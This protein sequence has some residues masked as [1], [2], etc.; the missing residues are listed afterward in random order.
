MIVVMMTKEKYFESEKL[1]SA[2]S[3]NRRIRNTEAIAANV[4]GCLRACQV[5][6]PARRVC[7]RV[8]VFV[9]V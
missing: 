9:C 6:A 4:R 1:K 5:R 7:V 8:N 2:K 3:N